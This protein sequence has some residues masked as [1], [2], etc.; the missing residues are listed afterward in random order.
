MGAFG[1]A[2]DRDTWMRARGWVLI[3]SIAMLSNSDANPRMFTVGKFGI[4]QILDDG[5]CLQL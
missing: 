4:G 5:F 1:S 2:V 3:L